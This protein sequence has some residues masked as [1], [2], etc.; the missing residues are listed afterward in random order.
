MSLSGGDGVTF[1]YG[2][3]ERNDSWRWEKLLLLI[4]TQTARAKGSVRS[5]DVNKCSGVCTGTGVN[6]MRMHLGGSDRETT[7]TNLHRG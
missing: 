4:R 1:S 6:G 5:T 3:C 7:S 2:D